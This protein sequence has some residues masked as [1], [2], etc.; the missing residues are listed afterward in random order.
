M[1]RRTAVLYRQVFQLLKRL[2]PRLVESLT[3]TISDFEAALVAAIQAE[4][5]LF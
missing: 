4:I 3:L 5:P 2:A 1:T